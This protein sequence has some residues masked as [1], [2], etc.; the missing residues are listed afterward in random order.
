MPAKQYLI[1]YKNSITIATAKRMPKIAT[2]GL[3]Y[4][5]LALTDFTMKKFTRY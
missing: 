2:I 5:L 1:D 3:Q 4:I